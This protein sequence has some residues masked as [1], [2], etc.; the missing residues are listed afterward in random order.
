M[1]SE[2]RQI[3]ALWGA[4]LAGSADGNGWRLTVAMVE[5]EW[6]GNGRRRLVGLGQRGES[7]KWEFWNLDAG[8]QM[9][10]KKGFK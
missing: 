5:R 9:E 1:E 6:G 3:V 2:V 10:R 7:S 8:S 4:L